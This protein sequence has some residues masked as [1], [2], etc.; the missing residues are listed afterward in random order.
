[1]PRHYT[2]TSHSRATQKREVAFSHLAGQSQ[3]K[4]RDKFV[5]FDA[6]IWVVFTV[7]DAIVRAANWALERIQRRW[8]S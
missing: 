8:I 4:F 7:L 5:M 2:S 3:L 6:F 1:M